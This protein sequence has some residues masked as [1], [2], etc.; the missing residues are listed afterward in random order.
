[1]TCA[2]LHRFLARPVLPALAALAFGTTLLAA[3]TDDRRV[4]QAA[5][6]RPVVRVGDASASAGGKVRGGLRVGDAADGTPIILPVTIVAGTRPGPVVWVQAGTHGDE[7]GGIR[8]LQEVVRDLDPATMAGTVVALMAANLPAFQGL[9]RVNPNPDDQADLSNLFPGDAGGFQADR[10]AAA[11][12]PL[13]TAQADYFIDLHTG[14]DRFRQQAF[15]LYTVTGTVAAERL[16]AL[17]RGFG[18]PT[19][20][21]DTL[22]IFPRKIFTVLAGAGIPS[23]LLEVGGGQPLEPADL[24]LQAD[25]VR[26]FLTAV[27]VLPGDPPRLPRHTI[28]DGYRIVTNGRGGFFE[29][30]VRPGDRIKSGDR[31]GFIRDVQGDIVETLIAPDGSDIV[32]GVGTYP[33]WPTG[34]WLIE[35]GSG[36]REEPARQ[37]PGRDA[38]SP[39]SRRPSRGSPG[40]DRRRARAPRRSPPR[41]RCWRRR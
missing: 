34:G 18:I 36:L 27:K 23:F 7:Y 30:A 2:P 17:A 12:H 1:M 37:G 13:I 16:D 26:G 28:L 6:G 31:L 40:R 20:W 22:R 39:A 21:R 11:L 4:V 35:I 14:G 41:H 8:A 3:A 33:A 10:I 15:V 19:L 32:L 38:G 24:R 29:P 25:A 5:G 9:G